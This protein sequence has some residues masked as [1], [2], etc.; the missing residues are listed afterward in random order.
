MLEVYIIMFFIAWLHDQKLIS[1]VKASPSCFNALFFYPNLHVF[2]H[3][4]NN[5]EVNKKHL[6][7]YSIAESFSLSGLFW[8]RDVINSP[9]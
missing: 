5:I 2:F 7:V 1:K 6:A 4:Y 3:H 9:L 8:R